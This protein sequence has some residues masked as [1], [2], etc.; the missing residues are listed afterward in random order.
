MQTNKITTKSFLVAGG[1][2][3]WQL[4]PC[5]KTP[6]WDHQGAGFLCKHLRILLRSLNLV[7]N[8][9]LQHSRWR[10]CCPK[11]RTG[12]FKIGSAVESKVIFKS[13]FRL[14]VWNHNLPTGCVQEHLEFVKFIVLSSDW[15]CLG[16]LFKFCCHSTFPVSFWNW[17]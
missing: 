2:G 10:E 9:A 17:V 7:C 12:H 13:L 5:G 4:R 3:D 11:L 16:G 6:Q 15:L 1:L 14:L 8:P